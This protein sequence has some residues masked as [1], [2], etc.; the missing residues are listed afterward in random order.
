M[1]D[2]SIWS[3]PHS[4]GPVDAVVAVPGSK[5]LTNRWLVLAALADGPCT[6]RRPLRSRDSERMVEALRCLGVVVDDGSED[7]WTVTAPDRLHGDTEV[8]C[9][10][11]GTV[12]RFV[13][14][15]AALAHGAV[16]F[17]GHPTARTRPVGPV[18]EGL[19]ALGVEVDDGGRG[20]LPYTVTGRGSV[21]GGH[22]PVDASA[23]SQ[24]VSA[25]LLA[26]ARFEEGLTLEHT[27]Q[28]LPSTTHVEMTVQALRAVGV[29]VDQPHARTWRIEPGPVRAF[30]VAV[31]PDLSSAA[32]FVALA[33]VTGGTVTVPGWPAVTTQPG[34]RLREILEL[35]GARTSLTEVGL[36]VRGPAGD[37]GRPARLAGVELDLSDVGELTPVVAALAALADG[38]SRL[39]GIGHLRGHETDRLAALVTEIGRLGGRAEETEDGL[40]VTPVPLHAARLRT[41]HDHRMAMFAAVVGAAVPGV[42]VE[43]VATADKTF[44]GFHEAWERAVGG[45]GAARGNAAAVQA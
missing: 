23:S 8:D 31:E 22:V 39:S 9:G 21:R 17:D 33:A 27:G 41:Y 15:I 13:P 38:P 24:F 32:P 36:V 43:D 16:R 34:D 4:P 1:T 10:Q 42:Q 18:L 25:L 44:P 37:D 40:T 2:P 19:R 11:A 7:A 29:R 5:S 30:D 12:M 45:D 6:L 26:G 14:P 3:A 35:M 20:T 28:T